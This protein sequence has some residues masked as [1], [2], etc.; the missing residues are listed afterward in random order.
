MPHAQVPDEPTNRY[1]PRRIAIYAVLAVGTVAIACLVVFLLFTDTFVN[2]LLKGRNI[3]NFEKSYPNYS[4]RIRGVGYDIWNNRLKCDSI[5]LTPTDS[6]FSCT[7]AAS[8]VSGIGWIQLFLGRALTPDHLANSGVDAEHFVL[9]FPRE[10]YQIRCGRLHVSVGDSEIVADSFEL[11]PID[12]DKQ[13]FAADK[14]RRTRYRLQ[15][16]HASMMGSTCLGL[17]R[18]DMYCGRVA[19]LEDPFLDI[20]TNK[21]KRPENDTT[22]PLMPYEVLSTIKAKLQIDSV[23]IV[24]GSL[25]YGERM[26]IGAPPAAITFDSMNV[27]IGGIANYCCDHDSTQVLAQG[28][29]MKAGTLNLRMSIPVATQE[30][31]LRY[32]G[33]LGRMPLTAFNPFIKVAEHVRIKSGEL[34]SATFAVTVK[35]GHADGSMRAAY[36]D[37]SVAMQDEQTGSEKGILNRLTSL[38]A[39]NMK[40]RT[41][42]MPDESGAM[43]IGVVSYSR[44]PDDTFFQ[45]LWF[46][47]RSGLKDVV[48]F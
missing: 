40:I 20:L 10:Q 46:S 24:N 41:D 11:G 7:I 22:D 17:L 15:V 35:S 30:F 16:A 12:D 9:T 2:E 8:S 37:L 25:R 32:S 38:V 42:N 6:G 45:F 29:F 19:R 43:K 3:R 31:S 18:R 14:F 47:V 44:K 26:S 33:S 1:S 36:S 4:L 5:S 13:F 23:N 21:D 28:R 27:S 39:N 34:Q 48:G